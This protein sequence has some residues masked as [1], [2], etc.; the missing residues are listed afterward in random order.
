LA[1]RPKSAI[2]GPNPFPDLLAQPAFIWDHTRRA[3]TWI[4]GAARLKFA[5][6]AAELEAALPA[7]LIRQFERCIEGGGR[8]AGASVKLK[9]GPNPPVNCSLELIELAGGHR[10]LIVAEAAVASD[11]A[12][13]FPPARKPNASL[14]GKAPSAAKSAQAPCQGY[15]P[16][17]QLTPE[18]LRAFKS[19]GRKVRR[20]AQQKQSARIS[21]DR[22]AGALP[23][24]TGPALDFHAASAILYSAFD[25]V[26]F[27]DKNFTILKC[28]G[29]PQRIGWR[30]QALPGKPAARLLPLHEQAAFA[31]MSKKVSLEAV[32]TCRDSF[33]VCGEAGAGTP[34]RL[35][36]GRWPDGDA[37]YFLALLSLA[38]PSRLKRL[39]TLADSLPHFPRLAA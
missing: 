20:L 12:S 37:P 39:K 8:K 2:A 4:N 19:I 31:R 7:A 17:P 5:L 27:L 21:P 35:I 32:Q 15:A 36:L 22:P 3:V 29:R 30:K 24:Q 16:I 34:C 18:E 25:L 13:S 9:L 38:M 11:A 14:P 1:A 10:G 28:E 33:I 26:L 6:S 23:L